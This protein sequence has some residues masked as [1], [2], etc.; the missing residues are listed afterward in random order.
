MTL[1]LHY[2]EV[3]RRGGWDHTGGV[4]G[5]LNDGGGGLVVVVVKCEILKRIPHLLYI[6]R[7]V[8]LYISSYC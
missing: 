1:L 8:E 4:K 2:G 6:C 7:D 3:D 5:S